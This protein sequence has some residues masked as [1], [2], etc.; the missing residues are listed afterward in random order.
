MTEELKNLS[1]LP[2][3]KFSQLRVLF[4]D[5]KNTSLRQKVS[6]WLKKGDI[7]ELKK[8]FYVANK[9]RERYISDYNYRVYLANILCHPSYVSGAYILQKEGAIMEAIYP[10]TSITT[11]STRKYSNK[12]GEFLYFSISEQ[13]YTGYKKDYYTNEP[14][15]IASLA[16]ALFDYLYIKYS[17]MSFTANNILA[18]ERFNIEV[19][20]RKDKNEFKHYCE[21][22]NNKLL[23]EVSKKV[24][25]KN[26]NMSYE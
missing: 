23:L 9:Y 12:L 26:I 8:G 4:P 24:F 1:F 18:R 13:L 20:A 11:K 19:F 10:I 6:R 2:Y 16:K 7:F 14:V 17:K 25:L 21:I 5:I 15:Y 22:S 3:F